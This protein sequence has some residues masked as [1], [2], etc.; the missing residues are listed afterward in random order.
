[1]AEG[2]LGHNY[3]VS[4]HDYFRSSLLYWLQLSGCLL[5]RIELMMGDRV[6]AIPG[7]CDRYNIRYIFKQ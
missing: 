6:A 4:G 2:I 1:M 3:T 5:E 7:I